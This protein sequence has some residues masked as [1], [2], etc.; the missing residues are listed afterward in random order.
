MAPIG[1]AAS[2]R[3]LRLLF[4]SA[5]LPALAGGVAF[6]RLSPQPGSAVEMPP[7]PPDDPPPTDAREQPPRQ[8]A[9]PLRRGLPVRPLIGAGLTA[10]AAA[11]ACRRAVASCLHG[12]LNRRAELEDDEE[13][14]EEEEGEEEEG[15]CKDGVCELPAHLAST[16]ASETPPSDAGASGEDDAIAAASAAGAFVAGDDPDATSLGAADEVAAAE[17][18]DSGGEEIV[19]A[20]EDFSADDEAAPEPAEPLTPHQ[21]F[22]RSLG[23]LQAQAGSSDFPAAARLISRYCLNAAQTPPNPKVRTRARMPPHLAAAAVPLPALQPPR[24]ATPR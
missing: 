17:A 10:L 20:E 24:L 16:D 23:E 9:L 19:L 15:L 21:T 1:V 12:L 2:I 7:P 22:C 11:P 13:E 3:A 8:V 5:A 14:E 6:D 4:V 18:A